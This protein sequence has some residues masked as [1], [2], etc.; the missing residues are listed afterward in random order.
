MKKMSFK[1]ILM[2]SLVTCMTFSCKDLTELNQNPNGVGPETV[3]PNLILPTVLTEAAKSYVNLG[4]QDIAGVVQHTQKDAW[5]N[6]HNDYDWGGSQSWNPYYDILRNNDL[7]YTRA[8]AT[9]FEFHQGVSLVIK[10][11][12]FGLITDLW[13]DAPYT[14]ALKGELGGKENTLPAFDNQEDI[15][16]R[17]LYIL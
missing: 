5:Y 13:G 6:G 11:F 15:F 4:Y 14:T 9:N 1:Y 3:N 12:M 10:S 8:V 17:N 2:L 16:S 7:L